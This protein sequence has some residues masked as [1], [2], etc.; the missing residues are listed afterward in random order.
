MILNRNRL[1]LSIPAECENEAYSATEMENDLRLF[2]KS[3]ILVKLN[4]SGVH[5]SFTRSDLYLNTEN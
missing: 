2:D 1:V 3:R 4:N 5:S